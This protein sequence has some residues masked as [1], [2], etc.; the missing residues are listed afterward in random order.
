MNKDEL[1][2]RFESAKELGEVGKVEGRSKMKWKKK[3][4]FSLEDIKQIIKKQ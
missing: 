3:Y 4:I 1:I 2:Q